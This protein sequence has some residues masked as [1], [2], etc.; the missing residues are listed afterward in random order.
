M[1]NVLIKEHRDGTEIVIDGVK[2]T[3]TSYIKIE[4]NGG[5]PMTV[6]IRGGR[7]RAGVKVRAVECENE[8]EA[9]HESA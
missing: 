6:E 4:K 9:D 5:E 2:V 3:G 8:S 1:R 7:F